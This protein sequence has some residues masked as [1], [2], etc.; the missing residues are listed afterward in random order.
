MRRNS[1]LTQ[2]LPECGLL[3]SSFSKLVSVGDSHEPGSRG[4]NAE[5]IKGGALGFS[6]NVAIS[7]M[8]VT[9]RTLLMAFCQ[10]FKSTL[11]H[12]SRC[13]SFT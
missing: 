7:R 8:C 6:R 1:V 13:S 2:G 10:E 3:T 4:V 9:S 11:R 12:P 5:K